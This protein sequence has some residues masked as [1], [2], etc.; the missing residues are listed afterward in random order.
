MIMKG[1]FKVA[2]YT[3]EGH[4]DSHKV[5]RVSLAVW[6]ERFWISLETAGLLP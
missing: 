4:P 2:N 5:E 3:M 1:I 6:K